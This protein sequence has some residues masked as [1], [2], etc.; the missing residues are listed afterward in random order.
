MQLKYSFKKEISHFIR[1]FRMIGVIIAIMSFAI[2]NPMMFKFTGTVLNEFS[3]DPDDSKP[4]F[5]ASIVKTAASFSQNEDISASDIFG[6]MDISEIADYYNDAGTMFSTTILTFAVYGL[7]ITMLILMSAS[8]GEQKKRAMIVPMCSGLDY[9]NYLLPKFLIYP[10]FVFAVTFLSS[11]TAGGLCNAMF[12]FN[13]ITPV[14][15]LMSSLMM[16][17]YMAFIVCV[18]MSLGLCTSRPGIMAPVVFVGQMFLDSVLSA[19]KITKYQ[20]F[21]LLSYCSSINASP[22]KGGVV[23]A[24]EAVSIMVSIALCIVISVLM[25]F[26]ALGVLK[27]KKIDNTEENRP[28][29]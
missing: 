27:A 21:A 4:S 13:K 3:G 14:N 26:L 10:V 2:S 7:L 29:F 16:S 23:L 18:F 19:M 11:L 6:E 9:Q 15:M 22:E 1:T 25:Y 24:D 28:E 17:V 5:T 20:P 12:E 8:G